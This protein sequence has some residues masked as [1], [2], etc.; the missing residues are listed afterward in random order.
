MNKKP[1][2]QKHHVVYSDNKR[3]EVIRKV[4]KGVHRIINFIK[5][6]NSLTDEEI[7]TIKLECE[8]KRKFG[9][10]ERLMV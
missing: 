2:F 5:L 10:E 4:R 7:A 9:T 1:V 3:Y 8:L 6:F